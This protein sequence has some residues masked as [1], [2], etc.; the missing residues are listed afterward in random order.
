MPW[1]QPKDNMQSLREGYTLGANY[2]DRRYQRQQDEQRM[3]MQVQQLEQERRMQD[4][5]QKLREEEAKR[6]TDEALKLDN[7]GKAFGS[8]LQEERQKEKPENVG[9]E[10][11]EITPEQ[12]QQAMSRTF[13]KTLP[14]LPANMIPGAVQS[15]M[16]NAARQMVNATKQQAVDDR[17][18]INEKNLELRQLLAEKTKESPKPYSYEDPDTGQ[19]AM[20]LGGTMIPSGV[21]PERLKDRT[22][23]DSTIIF[24]PKG[25]PMRIPNTALSRVNKNRDQILEYEKLRQTSPSDDRKR[26]VAEIN[27][28]QLE[29]DSI[30]AE[31]ASDQEMVTS[32]A[33]PKRTSPIDI[34]AER[35]IANAAIA[36]GAPKAAVADRFKKKTGKDL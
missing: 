10:Y 32:D 15:E 13:L 9:E 1:L 27:R 29:N 21:N 30:L 8:V 5:Q 28:L 4:T 6:R 36:K 24:S 7:Y 31:H 18:D 16:V 19:K 25:Q 26:Y 33:Q 20:I 22:V 2:S 35:K 23:G 34:E 14:L 12:D 3:A 11:W 17:R